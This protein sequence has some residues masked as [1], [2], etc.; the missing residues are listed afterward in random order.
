MNKGL[1]TIIFLLLMIFVF[2]TG[3]AAADS[4]S[5][6]SSEI[7]DSPPEYSLLFFRNDD[8]IWIIMPQKTT[9]VLIHS[10]DG[11]NPGFIQCIDSEGNTLAQQTNFIGLAFLGN[12]VKKPSLQKNLLAVTRYDGDAVGI[13]TPPNAAFIEIL[14]SRY[15]YDGIITVLDKKKKVLHRQTGLDIR[16]NNYEIKKPL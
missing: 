16:I 11:N 15:G 10:Y 4:K 6:S 7:I 2:L 9:F 12:P 5:S 14:N 3:S 8:R 13:H 1:K